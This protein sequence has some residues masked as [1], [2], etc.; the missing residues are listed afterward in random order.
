MRLFTTL[1]VIFL[2]ACTQS[3]QR[4][5]DALRD[6][7]EQEI[8]TVDGTI[9]VA[10]ISLE[11]PGDTLFIDA[12]RMYHAA[13]T[14]KTPVM[15]EAY[16]QAFDGGITIMD[17]VLVHNEFKSI[18]DGSVYSIQRDRDGGSDFHD[19]IGSYVPM[20][21]VIYNMTILSGNLATNLVI[22]IVGAEHV[23]RTMRELGAHQIEVLR[24]VE[25]M[26]A[27]QQGLNNRTSARDLAVIFEHLARGTAVSPEM[28][29]DM[30]SILK[31]Q[32]FRRMIPAGLPEN[33]RVAHKTGT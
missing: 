30:I 1:W 4:D 15:I 16:R 28:D 24:G 27:F 20:R 21:D 6:R 18:V 2:L 8:S 13:S 9:S 23:V 32:E 12:D 17:S 26:L 5:I 11:V 10:L 29:A 7:I 14:M 3:N 19:L 33:A 25:D 22:D 31:D